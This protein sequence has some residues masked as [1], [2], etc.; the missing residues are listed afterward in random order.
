MDIRKIKQIADDLGKPRKGIIE[1]FISDHQ[2][3]LKRNAE[4]IREVE[5][6]KRQNNERH[7]QLLA[8]EE[9]WNNCA[10]WPDQAHEI[11][12]LDRLIR[13]EDE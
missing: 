7:T 13:G 9:A 3:I 4:L 11:Q 12:N 6:L 2:Y 8:I 1:Q 5:K 10:R